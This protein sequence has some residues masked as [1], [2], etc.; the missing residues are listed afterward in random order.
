MH[1]FRLI[2]AETRTFAN[3]AIV[4]E[5]LTD[6]PVRLALATILGGFLELDFF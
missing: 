1:R 6:C 4:A 5:N 3:C 2:G